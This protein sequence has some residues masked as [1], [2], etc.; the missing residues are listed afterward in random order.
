MYNSKS[1]DSI[2]RP[3]VLDRWFPPGSGPIF[4]LPFAHEDQIIE[5][6]N[7]QVS[8]E[9]FFRFSSHS[10]SKLKAKVNSECNATKI[11][12]TL[13]SL[14]ALVWRCVTRARRLPAGEQ[15][16]CGLPVNN[17]ILTCNMVYGVSARATAGELLDHGVGRAALRLH[18]AVVNYGDK[19]IKEMMDFWV[20]SPFVVKL[21]QLFGRNR[22]CVQMGSSPRFDM[23]GNEFELGKA[24][25]VFGGYSYKFDGKV[26]LYPGRE[27][28][29]EHGFGS[30]PVARKH[31]GF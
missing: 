28:G 16:T 20:K 15:T 8:R 14:S 13:Q 3:P 4:A 1:R 26:T 5:R 6:P 17:R 31:G 21:D 22:N 9:R 7:H 23:Y 27:G 2:S 19:D 29:R 25:A 11:I 10:L 30:L 18:E 24:F 12:S